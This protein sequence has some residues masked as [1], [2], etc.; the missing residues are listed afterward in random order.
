MFRFCGFNPRPPSLAGEH[1]EWPRL[2][3]AIEFQSTPAITGGRTSLGRPTACNLRCFNPRPP[4]LAGEREHSC[5]P[6]MLPTVSIHA[7]H[8]WRANRARVQASNYIQPVSIH[9]RHHWRANRSSRAAANSPNRFNPRPPSLAG[10]HYKNKPGHFEK[11]FQSTPAITGG[12]TSLQAMS[13][14]ST[15]CFNPRPPS[16]AGERVSWLDTQDLV[17]FQSTPAITG[18]RTAF[19]DC[20]C[21]SSCGFN[22]RPPSLAGERTTLQSQALR[23]MFQSTPAI[24]GGRTYC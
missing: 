18:G 22:P 19:I 20:P 3:E 9:A 14:S 24:T 8:H 11:V 23:N 10:E 4:S 6:A 15:T 7:R 16:L 21:L 12:R 1:D 5:P 17:V 13:R 2:T